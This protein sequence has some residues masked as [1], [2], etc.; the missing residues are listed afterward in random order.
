M[1]HLAPTELVSEG[2]AMNGKKLPTSKQAEYE[3]Y[4]VIGFGGG[5]A[6][7]EYNAMLHEPFEPVE[8]EIEFLVPGKNFDAELNHASG[9]D[10]ETEVFGQGL[11][12]NFEI[13]YHFEMAKAQTVVK[14]VDDKS[15]AGFSLADEDGGDFFL[16]QLYRCVARTTIAT[17]CQPTPTTIVHRDPYYGVPLFYTASGYSSCHH[18]MGTLP[19]SV[20]T[21]SA[22]YIGPLDGELDP[23]QPAIFDVVISNE[24]GFFEE[25]QCRSD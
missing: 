22:T 13:G 21:I 8:T 12:A 5:G 24:F 3:A 23:A 18:E 19:R 14:T 6:A 20:P 7:L 2:K 9:A 16:V 11:E 4:N 1:D 15:H 25:G 17:Q 10:L